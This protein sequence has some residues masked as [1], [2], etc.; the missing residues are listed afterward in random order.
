MNVC[1]SVSLRLGILHERGRVLVEQLRPDR[2]VERLALVIP[3]AERSG[4][5]FRQAPISCGCS[6]SIRSSR[7]P[8][9]RSSRGPSSAYRSRFRTAGKGAVITPT[10][11]LTQWCT[12]RAPVSEPPRGAF[13]RD[14]T[15]LQLIRAYS[16]GAEGL[17]FRL[18]LASPY[19][20]LVERLAGLDAPRAKREVRTL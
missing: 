13:S 9:S 11:R 20:A 17:A 1:A 16:A 12:S 2:T 6:R 7:Q 18:R 5:R 19:D 10:Y 4:S 15:V 3:Y 14:M 8:P